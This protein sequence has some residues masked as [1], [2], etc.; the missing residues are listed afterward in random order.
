VL[1]G[2]GFPGLA[3]AAQ[4]DGGFGAGFGCVQDRAEFLEVARDLGRLCNP[5]LPGRRQLKEETLR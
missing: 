1:G 2:G 4:D 5:G 3:G